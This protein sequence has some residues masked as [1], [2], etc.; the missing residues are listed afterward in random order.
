V[1][2]NVLFMMFFITD[3]TAQKDFL[4]IEGNTK[5]MSTTSN[6]IAMKFWIQS[7][8]YI[9]IWLL[10][11]KIFLMACL[12]LMQIPSLGLKITCSLS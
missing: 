10:K 9:L 12:I 11:D 6:N 2:K 1:S 8:Q 5:Y 4:P 7:L 3:M